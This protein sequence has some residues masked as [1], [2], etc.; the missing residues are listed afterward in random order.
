MNGCVEVE[1]LELVTDDENSV[2][3]ILDV[4]VEL[5]VVVDVVVDVVVP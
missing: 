1:L 2:L 5:I 4:K 3:V